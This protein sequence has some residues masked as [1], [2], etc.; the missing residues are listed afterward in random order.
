[1][2]ERRWDSRS[3]DSCLKQW[4]KMRKECSSFHS[5]VKRI[6]AVELTGSPT[7]QDLE[8]CAM[9]SIISVLELCCIFTIS[10]AIRNTLSLKSVRIPTCMYFCHNR[11]TL[12]ESFSQEANE[13]IN[14]DAEERT[15]RTRPLGTKA[16]K[17]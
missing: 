8:R 7:A 16:A 11:T 1:M 12:L 5:A 9:I 17:E 14:D 2:D 13:Y 15:L 4:I 10:S 3:P 6:E